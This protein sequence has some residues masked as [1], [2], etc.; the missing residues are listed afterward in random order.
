MNAAKS[1]GA[2]VR[3]PHKKIKVDFERAPLKVRLKE[4]YLTLFFLKKVVWYLFRLALLLGIAYVI[5]L[6]FISKISDSF[7]EFQDFA[8]QTVNLVPKHYTLNTYI[9][10]FNDRYVPALANTLMLSAGCAVIQTFVCCLIGYGF[11]KFKFK[12][13]KILFMLV[14]LTMIIPH[15]TLNLSM[16]SHFLHFDITDPISVLF[17]G[18]GIFELFGQAGGIDMLN[19]YFPFIILSI[20]GL[21][22]KNGL[23]IFLF[24]QFF[25]GVPDELEESAY[26]DGSGPFKT[27]FK[28]ILPLSTPMLIT[29][30]LFSF[31]WQWMDTFYSGLFIESGT[32]AELLSNIVDKAPSA[33]EKLMASGNNTVEVSGKISAGIRGTTGI[34]IIMPLV[35]VYVFCQ[36][37]LVQ[38]IERSGLTAD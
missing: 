23:Y 6:P 28:I 30:F 14:M 24:R 1:Q 32:G 17:G 22:F 7:K 2:F 12:G 25:R 16:A 18:K 10:I 20:F 31:S 19:T 35:I 37:F 21:G 3:D 8:D 26:I 36:K 38:G 5:L 4:K 33:L 27:F 13:S 11:A 9:E 15:Q 34:M 29:V